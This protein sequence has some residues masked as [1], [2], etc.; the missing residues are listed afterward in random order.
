MQRFE[1]VVLTYERIHSEVLADAMHQ[2]SMQANASPEAR[3]HIEMQSC[4]SA[5]VLRVVAVIVVAVDGYVYIYT[6]TPAAIAISID[7]AMPTAT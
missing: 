5:C 6:A 4:A 1:G 7:T 3:R 2:A